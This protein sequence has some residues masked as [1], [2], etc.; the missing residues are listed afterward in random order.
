MEARTEHFSLNFSK[1]NHNLK[2]TINPF[3]PINDGVEGAEYLFYFACHIFLPLKKIF[4]LASQQCY[5]HLF[6][7][8]PFL[9]VIVVYFNGRVFF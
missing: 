5:D 2:D 1:F 3:C 8:T 6:K 4:S 9:F 7:S